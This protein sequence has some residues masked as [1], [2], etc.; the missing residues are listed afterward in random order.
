M[1]TNQH[2]KLND[3]EMNLINKWR[4]YLS[5]KDQNPELRTIRSILIDHKF[6]TLM[7]KKDHN[8]RVIK[9]SEEKLLQSFCD[10]FDHKSIILTK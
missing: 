7:Q 10:K 1:N 5:Q 3:F 4:I 8:Y 6:R 9:E 2:D